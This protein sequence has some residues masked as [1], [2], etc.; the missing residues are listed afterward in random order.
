M[1]TLFPRLSPA[2]PGN[3]VARNRRRSDRRERPTRCW[4]A[5]SYRDPQRCA[6]GSGNSAKSPV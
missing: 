6:T 5:G 3:V 4:L 1:R 2:G